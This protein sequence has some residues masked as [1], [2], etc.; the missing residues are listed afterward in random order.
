VKL[1]TLP[2]DG[3]RPLVAAIR[4]ARRSI[5]LVVFRFDLDEIEEELGAA[6]ER[7]VGVRRWWLTPTPAATSCSGSSSS[8]C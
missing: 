1:L 7:G 5:D 8:A 3:I 4:T 2:K 6:V